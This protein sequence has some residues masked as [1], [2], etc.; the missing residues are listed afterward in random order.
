MIPTADAATYR[1]TR[2]QIEGRKMYQLT[3]STRIKRNLFRSTGRSLSVPRWS[4]SQ[5]LCCLAA[6]WLVIGA[7]AAYD[8]YLTVQFQ[9][10]MHLLE[11]NPVGRWLIQMNDGSVA[12]F[13]GAK[14]VG[15][16]L[17]LGAIPLLYLRQR[18]LGVV[19]ASGVAVCQVVLLCYLTIA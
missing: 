13:V 14:F 12:L 6:T 3:H 8:T 17:V 9:E 7:V 1:K 16:I 11:Q 18:T 10:T 5:Q 2:H 19:V 15:T 4:H